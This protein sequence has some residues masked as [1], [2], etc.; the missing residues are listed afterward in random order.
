ME[1]ARLCAS[2][3]L[4]PAY[5]ESEHTSARRA[6]GIPADAERN[7]SEWSADYGERSTVCIERAPPRLS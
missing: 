2:K 7:G 3:E 5:L 4:L 6:K 1:S